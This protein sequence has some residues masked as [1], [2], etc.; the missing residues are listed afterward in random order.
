MRTFGA[1]LIAVC[2]L[3]LAVVV[4]GCGGGDDEK[5][6]DVAILSVDPQESYPGVDTE[7]SFEITPGEGTS[8]DELSY[9]VRFGDQN[10]TT[11]DELA[12]SVSHAYEGSGRFSLEVAAM[13]GDTQVGSATQSVRV[14][15]PVDLTLS[16]TRGTPAN[17]EPGDELTISLSA[18]N[19][20]AGPVHSPFEVSFYLSESS[21]VALEDIPDLPE[22]GSRAVTASEDSEPVIEA[23][24]SLSPGLTVEVPDDIGS[25]DYRI[26]A[27]I[28]P[29]GQ[30]ADT[31]PD[32]NFDVSQSI[33]RVENPD[34]VLPDVAVDEV[35]L[36]PER[37]FPA[38]NQIT[39]TFTIRNEGSAEAFDVVVRS[40]L[41]IGDA[42]L[43]EDEDILLE[44]SD[45]VDVAPNGSEVFDPEEFVLDDDIVPS[46]GEEIEVY[47]IVEAHLQGDAPE[48]GLENNT[49]ISEPTVVSDER[50]D[51][52]DI[53]VRDFSITPHSTFL[54]GTLEA[55]LELANE[56]T[57]DAGS[58]FCGI[59]MSDDAT[60]DTEVDPRFTNVNISGL[61]SEAERTI[62]QSFVFSS[63]Y[64]PGTYY[65][66]VVCD[67]LG[68]LSEPYR[69]NNQKMYVE[70]ITITDE[71]DVDMYV[72]ELSVPTD[73]DEGD[74]V[75]LTATICVSGS[76][77]SGS[78]RGRLYRSPGGAPDFSGEPLTVFDIPNINPG[79]CEDVV[80][81]TDAGCQDFEDQYGYGVQVDFDNRL[82]ESDE[83][84]NRTVGT[85]LLTVAG[86]YC[87]CSPDSFGNDNASSGFPLTQGSHSDS[88]CEPEQCDF[89]AVD[90]LEDESLLVATTYETAQGK[91]ETELFDSSG[92]SLID[93]SS[94]DGRQEV[95]TFLVPSDGRYKFS[96]CG[97]DSDTQNLYD[98]DVQ[99]LEPSPG[100]DV[101]PRNLELPQRD[102]FS[103]GSQLDISFRVYNI[104]QTAT[105][106]SFDANLVLSSNETLGDS[107]DIA[108]QPSSV[109]VE[110]VAGGGSK[111]I[112]A[113]VE[114][115]EAVSDGDYY[116]GV[117]LDISDD[118]TT[119]NTVLSRPLNVETL[120]YDP[121]EPNDSF[122]EA[123]GLDHG[124]FSNLIACT[125]GDD[126]YEICAQNG[127]KFTVTANF[128]DTEGDIDLEL[129]DQQFQVIDSSANAGV[130]TES[131]SV[132]YVNGDQCYYARVYLLTLQEDLQTSYDIDVDIN[133]VPP[134]LQCDGLFEPNDTPDTASSL[135]SAVA[136]D[137]TLD[138]CP[139]PD[140]DYYYV[141][142]SSGQTV[143]LR[144]I[145]DPSQQAGTLRMQLYKPNGS[146]GPNRETAPG[147][148]TA[149][150]ADYT[151]PSSGTYL[152]QVTVSGDERRVTYRLEADGVGGIDLEAANLAIGPGTY[153]PSDEVRFGFDLSNMLSDTATA[154]TYTVWLSDSQ[155]HDSNN[156][157]QLGSFSLSDD[158]AGSSTVSVA[159]RV[160]LPS[161]GLWDGTGYLH[162]VVEANGQTDANLS[163]NVATT[164][165]SLSSN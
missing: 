130:D 131:V 141:Q 134:S 156:D 119:N 44:E 126:F 54:D 2:V 87:S 72:D 70:P 116:M 128:D 132:D 51:G 109:T 35:V 140:T 77:P 62:E 99:I 23:G 92:V 40:W 138:R 6:A 85:N 118:D 102:S 39:R 114:I 108:L 26:V 25:G 153:A 110:E 148:D 122:T 107:D 80:L 37:A 84:N 50:V 49:G 59:Y 12:A 147:Q 112:N 13:V 149:E 4:T 24:Q 38:L 135:L 45:P 46:S 9:E 66:Y 98:V 160:D 90:L 150:L 113:T 117:S 155:T 101:L 157:T 129:Y 161:S 91:L 151:A 127:E 48:A 137:S 61:D 53:V 1:A 139:E 154:P 106:G 32:N 95:A 93:R 88:I 36:I 43:D 22:L 27:W 158:V 64:D 89:Y 143:S 86:D 34:E 17:V 41:S 42:E 165:V 55:T 58:F 123:Y 163:N 133:D 136:Q 10:S 60:I 20:E 146:P 105:A 21:S 78:T 82:P 15:D 63:Q 83:D 144:G 75:E 74:Q 97:A 162:V 69:S 145:V 5:T 67:P 29:E 152:L 19:V 71:A 103:V 57:L 96:V 65:M 18:S 73:A 68:A 16:D 56:G 11:G 125:E 124:S 100:V 3:P 52:T 115:P 76:N 81:T 31:D 94:A 121:L 14:L 79:T 33:V 28:N 7:V 142:L 120:C 104:G 111:D 159:D 164:S 8:A 47:L 30:L